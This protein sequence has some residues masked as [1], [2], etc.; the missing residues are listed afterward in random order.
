MKA[1]AHLDLQRAENLW[2]VQYHTPELTLP[3]CTSKVSLESLLQHYANPHI[4]LIV[5]DSVFARRFYV[6]RV[7]PALRWFCKKYGVSTPSWLNG[8][9][10]Y[11]ELPPEQFAE[12]F[13]EGGPLKVREFEEQQ[14]V[15]KEQAALE[16]P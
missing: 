9:A 6:E 2:K 3:R 13:G 5:P 8:N 12:Y 10:H 15:P 7:R 14:V 4:R 1:R 16:A 11:D